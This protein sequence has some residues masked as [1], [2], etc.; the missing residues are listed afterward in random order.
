MISKH[1]SLLLLNLNAP[2]QIGKCTP[3]Q[4]RRQEVFTMGALCLCGGALCL[5]QGGLILKI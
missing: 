3:R 5:C 1:F 2:H 4:N